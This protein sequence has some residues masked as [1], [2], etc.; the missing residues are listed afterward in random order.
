MDDI[1]CNYMILKLKERGISYIE[2]GPLEKNEY[3]FCNGK[4]FYNGTYIDLTLVSSVYVR[5]NMTFSPKNL[6]DSYLDTYNHQNLLN[7]QI[8]NIRAWLKILHDQGITVINPPIDNSKYYQLF[9]LINAKIPIPQTCIT[10]SYDELQNFINQVGQ[11]IYKPLIGGYHCR[12]VD[13]SVLEFLRTTQSEPIIFQEYIN[14]LDIRV[15]LLNG[16]VISSHI[17]EKNED[18]LDYRENPDFST[19]EFLYTPVDL[20]D[21]VIEFCKVAAKTLNL[22]FTGI[23]IKLNEK[24]DYYLLECN[25]KPIYID[26]EMKLKVPITDKIIDDLVNQTSTSKKAISLKKPTLRLNTREYNNKFI[27]DYKRIYQ[28]DYQRRKIKNPEII[29]SLNEEQLKDIQ[30]I[31]KYKDSKYMIVSV[32]NNEIKINGF[33]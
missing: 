4:L 2:L 26:A 10:N 7:T 22:Y 9:R 27:F 6:N 33:I 5:G 24:G 18:Y 31:E 20:P 23:D 32:D 12:K 1:H 25:S 17:I 21:Y 15:Y 29:V 13:N 14:G 3:T 30:K 8:E 19:G 11:V 28:A 16:E